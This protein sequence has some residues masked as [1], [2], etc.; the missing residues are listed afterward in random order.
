[1]SSL[2]MKIV[3]HILDSS[4]TCSDQKIG[5]SHEDKCADLDVE[6]QEEDNLGYGA[7]TSGGFTSVI[8][9]TP[10]LN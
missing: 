6:S 5:N 3:R 2:S 8:S 1:M 10:I 7:C 9:L 4:M